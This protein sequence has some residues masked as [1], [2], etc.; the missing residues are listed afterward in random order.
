MDALYVPLVPDFINHLELRL[1]RDLTAAVEDWSS[2]VTVLTH[3]ED[4]HL[5]ENPT[6]QLRARHKQ[7]T[8]RL[9][10]F[11]QFL[12][13]ATEQPEFSHQQLAEI[14]AA[15]LRCLRDKLS[16]W[17]GPVMSEERRAEILKAYSVSTSGRTSGGGRCLYHVK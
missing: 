8:E 14:V 12:A 13:L 9:L 15:T 16:L 6:P 5:I 2:C 7:T 11:G 10:R 3:W 1:Q 4:E 17:H